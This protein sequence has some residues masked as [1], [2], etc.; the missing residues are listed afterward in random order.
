MLDETGARALIARQRARTR[1]L[2]VVV[3][4]AMLLNAGIVT[5][6]VALAS[7]SLVAAAA[8]PALIA[9][10]AIVTTAV[11]SQPQ[12]RAVYLDADASRPY[13]DRAEPIVARVA[14]AL[15]V[16][17]PGVR[18]ADDEALNAYAAKDTV[19]Y[20]QGLL[21][22]VDDEELAAVTA[23]LLSRQACGENSLAVFG[24]GMMAWALEPF[25]LVVMRLVRLL[26]RTGK[27]CINFGLGRNTSYD[28][29][30]AGFAFRLFVF[31]ASL[32][33]GLE[34]LAAAL[35]LFLIFGA[36]A[37]VGVLTLRALAWQRMRFAD[38][39]AAAVTD[40]AAAQA[41]LSTLADL[42]TEISHG[43][44]TLPDLCFAGPRPMP[45][46]VPYTPGL[47][48]RIAW[49]ESGA[50]RG[51]SGLPVP[52]VSAVAL[53]VLL[54]GL[55]LGTAKVPFGKPFGH[56][57]GSVPV[58]G[59]AP[60]GLSG[61]TP[62]PSAQAT[63]TSSAPAQPPPI[64]DSSG[65]TGS[66]SGQSSSPH[67]SLGTSPTRS[68]TPVHNPT[69]SG[70]PAAPSGVKATPNGQYSITVT[71][72]SNA[73]NATGFTIDNGCPPGS[74]QPGATLT[75]TTGMTS[76]ATFAVTPGSYQCFRVQAFNSTASSTW[77]SYGCT[78]TPGFTLQGTQAWAST[79]V[80]VPSGIVLGIA[81][82]G[83]V[84]VTSS[85]SVNPAGTQSCLPSSNY[86]GANP[87]FPAAHLPC[88]SLIG[89]IGNG[90]PFEIGTST[91]ITTT[92]PGLL[93]LSVNDNNFADNSG[94]WL[95]D[96]KEGGSA[97]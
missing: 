54:G 5:L 12:S 61:T 84:Y 26:R 35:A 86:P 51:N 13:R 4:T 9:V 56:G 49:L 72:V 94:S 8:V 15:H 97:T 91:T 19:A 83:T 46:Y 6:I 45:G 65:L 85:Y 74:C 53:V 71:W 57:G 68:S 70:P 66:P 32:A 21:L 39:V 1:V 50:E 27:A 44:V 18:I 96:I 36:L 34:L 41:A 10:A 77:S 30:G 60:A 92:S 17:A 89:R 43:G 22:S 67:P 38:Q 81:A 78:Q 33:L 7:R 42:P 40:P 16:G 76:T 31:V 2:G 80:T 58:A 75:Q 37:L 23:H 87:P 11:T 14:A 69:P 52:L 20:T 73:G 90:P 3:A 25:D 48:L 95:V 59:T 88:W 62:T 29:D 64:T 93:Y 55:A 79:G 82:S 28:D 63:A 24:Y 47:G